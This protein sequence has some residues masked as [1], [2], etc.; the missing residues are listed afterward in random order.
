MEVPE[1]MMPLF[2]R[3]QYLRGAVVLTLKHTF[4]SV[5]L[6]SFRVAVT[7]SV[8]G[9]EKE[10]QR[11]STVFMCGFIDLFSSLGCYI[12]LPVQTKL[13]HLFDKVRTHLWNC[14]NEYVSSVCERLHKVSH[15]HYTLNIKTVEKSSNVCKPLF[16]Y[17]CHARSQK[18]DA[19]ENLQMLMYFSLLVLHLHCSPLDHLTTLVHT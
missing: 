15:K 5:G 12:S 18:L 2:G 17:S 3:T 4:L 8:N 13:P 9:P 10:T 19:V 1:S 14:K 6:V 7:T 16:Y 11:N